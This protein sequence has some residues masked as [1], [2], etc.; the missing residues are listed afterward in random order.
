MG[1]NRDYSVRDNRNAAFPSLPQQHRR[2]P[3]Q[4]LQVDLRALLP[5]QVSSSSGT[6]KL[7]FL[8]VDMFF[9]RYE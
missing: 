5:V 8:S 9:L 1:Q 2:H 4:K 3:G 6:A 7:R